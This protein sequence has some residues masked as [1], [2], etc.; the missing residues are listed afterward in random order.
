MTREDF[1]KA[2]SEI[3]NTALSFAERARREGLLTLDDDIDRKK[4]EERDIFH[5]GLRFVVDGTD[6]EII[7][8]I[9]TNIIEQE[10]DGYSLML[11]KIQKEA[12][13]CIQNGFNPRLMYYLLN[14]Y[15]DISIK[16]DGVFAEDE[17]EPDTDAPHEAY[18]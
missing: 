15:T 9:L 5:F 17:P 16:E 13:L 8:K 12:V 6:Q 1:F 18:V 3:V 14:S 4:E 2:Y 10:K 7:N 11:K